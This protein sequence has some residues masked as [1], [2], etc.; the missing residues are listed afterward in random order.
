MECFTIIVSGDHLG[1]SKSTL[2][3]NGELGIVQGLS[4]SLRVGHQLLES[5]TH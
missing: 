1:E 3:L 2:N 4:S 5:D